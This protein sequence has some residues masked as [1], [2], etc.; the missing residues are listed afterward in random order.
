MV[1]KIGVALAESRLRESAKCTA[2]HVTGSEFDADGSGGRISGDLS[3]RGT[4]RAVMAGLERRL[5]ELGRDRIE[6]GRDC[7][8]SESRYSALPH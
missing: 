6:L 4:A 3:D 2:G 5:N 1:R 8:F 7:T